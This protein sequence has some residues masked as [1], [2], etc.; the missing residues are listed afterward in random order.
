MNMRTARGFTLIE[1]MI[2][3]VIIAI[4]MAVA[5]PSYKAY[6]VKSKRAAAHSCIAEL[7]AMMEQVYADEF[8]F[9]IDVDGDGS[10]ETGNG[11]GVCAADGS[12]CESFYDMNDAANRPFKQCVEDLEGT[13]TIKPK[14]VTDRTFSIVAKPDSAD[15]DSACGEMSI[16]HNGSSSASGSLG[17]DCFPN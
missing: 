4:L 1:L 10:T 15:F 16:D 13:Y 17:D 3:I 14:S 11:S 2:V 8:S 9:K 7:S 6:V 12:D 5:V